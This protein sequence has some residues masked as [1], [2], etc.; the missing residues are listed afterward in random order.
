MR[1]APTWTRLPLSFQLLPFMVWLPVV[2]ASL[3]A[4]PSLTVT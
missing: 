1:D 3:S 2:L 4:P